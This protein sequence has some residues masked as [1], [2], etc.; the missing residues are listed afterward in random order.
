MLQFFFGLFGLRHAEFYAQSTSP[1]TVDHP[2][3]IGRSAH[4]FVF[5]TVV[6]AILLLR[7]TRPPLVA[8]SRTHDWGPQTSSQVSLALRADATCGGGE[9]RIQKKNVVKVL[10][11]RELNPGLRRICAEN[12]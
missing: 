3:E 1:K 7:P 6:F 10:R 2:A 8:V 4:R 9:K 11:I 5:F 12:R